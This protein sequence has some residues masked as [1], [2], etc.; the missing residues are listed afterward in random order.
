[1]LKDITS[2]FVGK[3]S[4]KRYITALYVAVRAIAIYFNHPFPA[5][6]DQIALAFGI[7]AAGDALKKIEPK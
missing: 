4:V 1:M 7:W 2:W 5:I 3:D 6:A